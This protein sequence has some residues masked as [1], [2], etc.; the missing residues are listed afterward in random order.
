MEIANQQRINELN[1]LGLSK[2]KQCE[3]YY[4]HEIAKEYKIKYSKVKKNELINKIIEYENNN[5]KYYS[6][7]NNSI[8]DTE[9]GEKLT[10]QERRFQLNSFGFKKPKQGQTECIKYIAN[11]CN[12]FLSP[13]YG[14]DESIREILK[15]EIQ[16]NIIT[17]TLQTAVVTPLY[18]YAG[19]S[20]ILPASQFGPNQL[21]FNYEG[22]D[23]HCVRLHNNSHYNP[24]A[25]YFPEH[26]IYEKRYIDFV[27]HLDN[28]KNK[29]NLD[30]HYLYHISQLRD[31]E[32]YWINQYC[33]NV[34]YD[35][36][37]N[38]NW[39]HNNDDY[40]TQHYVDEKYKVKDEN[41]IL[42]EKLEEITYN[43]KNKEDNESCNICMSEF[44]DGEKI[45]M[46]SC[47]HKFHSECIKEWVLRNPTCPC[48]RIIIN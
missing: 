30:T 19:A 16:N 29:L 47:K 39:V 17:G 23:L 34:G 38:I 10:V 1:N 9:N 22:E 5:N 4:L 13:Y 12:I 20:V 41:E 2:P 45:K 24:R 28:I 40:T 44:E 6:L 36:C 3:K 21:T 33:V 43:R 14:K 31:N 42:L 15:Y 27:K 35:I 32:I 46:V 8:F 48:C 7:D 11:R 37:I 18:Q 26:I 25:Y